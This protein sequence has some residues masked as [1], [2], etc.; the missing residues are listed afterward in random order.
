M[1]IRKYVIDDKV[2]SMAR[3]ISASS[4]QPAEVFGL[5]GRGVI[6]RGAYADIAVFDP[7]TIR[8]ESTFLEPTLLATGMR[9]VMVN[10]ALA[11]DGGVPTRLF[12]GKV[13]RRSDRPRAASDDRD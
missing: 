11:V 7:A 5:A 4:R 2:I 1:K 13:L 8:D 9:Y 12:A 10:G 3:M 6:V